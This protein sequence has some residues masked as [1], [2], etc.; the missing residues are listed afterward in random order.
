ML[1]HVRDDQLL[2]RDEVG[3]CE[4]TDRSAAFGPQ[5]NGVQ[6]AGNRRVAGVK[7]LRQLVEVDH[8]RG[9]GLQSPEELLREAETV[10]HD[11]IR[12]GLL[13]EWYRGSNPLTLATGSERPQQGCEQ[14]TDDR[15]GPH[16]AGSTPT[17]R[18]GGRS[19]G[20]RCCSGGPPHPEDL[21]REA[22][23]P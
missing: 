7:L 1:L 10:H 19:L 14:T 6:F 4:C 3:A 2:A 5:A 9:D 16:A 13:D 17:V 12:G 21:V 8:R 15:S 18:R 11:E 20:G 22:T 23:E